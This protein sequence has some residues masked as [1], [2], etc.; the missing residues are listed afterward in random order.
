[1]STQ[2]TNDNAVVTNHPQSSSTSTEDR[3]NTMSHQHVIEICVADLPAAFAAVEAG[4][5]RIEYCANI[6]EGG[7]TPT[8]ADVEQLLSNLHGDL[9]V[10]IRCRTGN[11]VYTPA[12]VDTMCDQIRSLKQLHVPEGMRF[13]FVVGALTEDGHIDTAACDR[14]REAAGDSPLTFH[15]AI[16]E[17]TDW[18]EALQYLIDSGF[19]RVLTTGQRAGQQLAEENAPTL[20]GLRAG[21]GYS[22]AG[23]AA[24]VDATRNTGLTI[25]ASGGIRPEAWDPTLIGAAGVREFHLRAPWGEADTPDQASGGLNPAIVRVMRT[26]LP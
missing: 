6:E 24:M 26:L 9:Q 17:V 11:F 2:V 25:L 16:E 22:V 1:M 20:K 8:A 10:M 12:E 3:F 14:F 4:A 7:T 15:R 21:T 19:E 13:G 23:L 5:D 18:K